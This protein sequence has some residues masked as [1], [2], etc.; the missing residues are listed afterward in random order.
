[1]T[2]PPLKT[3]RQ[4]RRDATYREIKTLAWEQLAQRGASSLSLR[5]ISR[6]M[7]MSSAALYRYYDNRSSLISELMRD[8]FRSINASMR[9]AAGVLPPHN[10]FQRIAAACRAYRAWALANPEKY[11]LIYGSPIAGYQTDWESLLNDAKEGLEIMLEL[12]RQAW[13]DGAVLPASQANELPP[14]LRLELQRIVHDREYLVPPEI[15]Y[16]VLIGWARLHGLVSLEVF[17]HV[18]PLLQDM[19]AIYEHE[20]KTLL[21]QVGY[22]S[23]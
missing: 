8:A 13:L 18:S 4:E 1:M 14:A 2:L 17:G 16:I 7:R 22:A 3:R 21:T 15:L 6:A 11:A 5:D 20:I 10:H 9:S 12:V 23:H 19:D